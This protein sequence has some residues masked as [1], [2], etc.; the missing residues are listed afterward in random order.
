M[1]N[2]NKKKRTYK[3]RVRKTRGRKHSVTGPFHAIVAGD[4]FGP[5]K[6]CNMSFGQSIRL[7]GGLAR[8][9]AEFIYRLN[10]PWDPDYSIGGNS[11][12]GWNQVALLY[13]KYKVNSVTF[14]I[15]F[16]D[17]SHD[18]SCIGITIQP[19]GG[20]ATLFNKLPSDV[21]TQPM[22]I[23]RVINNTGSQKIVIQQKMPIHVLIGCTAEQYRS[24]LD[25]FIGTSDGL[26]PAGDADQAFMRL[27]LC[28]DRNLGGTTILAR[29]K[30]TY[31]MTWFNRVT[32]APST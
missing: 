10:N 21:M 18:G 13:N 31:N 28:S 5:S 6:T 2:G 8:F 32:F 16:S 20:V 29:I 7:T 26:L 14:K 9:G 27:A 15:I 19:P 25:R 30:I 22:S 17:P 11:V 23:T 4:P 1:V 24:N 3:K 12:Y